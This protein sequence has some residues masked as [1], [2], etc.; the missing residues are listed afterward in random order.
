MIGR[1]L[2]AATDERHND[3]V[4]SLDKFIELGI[5]CYGNDDICNHHKGC[6]TIKKVLRI[7]GFKIQTFDLV[8]NVPNNAF[9]IDTDDGVRILYCTDTQYIPKVVKGVHYAI[10]ECNHDID[11][12]ID[13]QVDENFVSQSQHDNHQSLERCVEYLKRINNKD[14]QCVILWHMSSTNIDPIKAQKKVREEMSFPNVEIGCKGLEISL[15]KEE[16]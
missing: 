3:H 7:D 11:E 13:H 4:K 6:N 1:L 12:M 5:P 10:I 2:Y 15:N 14:L 9:V 8:H 16:F